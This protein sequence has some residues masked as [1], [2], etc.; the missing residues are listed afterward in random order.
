MTQGAVQPDRGTYQITSNTATRRFEVCTGDDVVVA[1][2]I[3]SCSLS[4]PRGFYRLVVLGEGE[5]G[6]SSSEFAVT[7]PGSMTF[8]DPN[9]TVEN[10]GLVLGIS[11]SVLLFTGSLLLLSAICIDECPDNNARRDRALIGLGA[12]VTGI[13][14]TPVGWSMFHRGRT[15]Y[16]HEQTQP[17]LRVGVAPSHGGGLLAV[18]GS[19]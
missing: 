3:G 7:G 1:R 19:F 8:D 10:T 17:T 6:V 13:V 18:V 11:G 9:P 12:L 2:C 14:L 15:P 16:L 5:R 4:L